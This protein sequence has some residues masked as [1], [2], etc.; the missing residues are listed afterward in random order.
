[1]RI[2]G[3][4]PGKTGGVCIL[5]ER[6]QI[7]DLRRLEPETLP[8]LFK[9]A[10]PHHVAI[11]HAQAFPKDTPLTAFKYGVGFGRLLQ[12]VDVMKLPYTLVKPREWQKIM[13]KGATHWQKSDKSAPKK[14]S[15]EIAR[16]IWPGQ[17]FL[18]TPRCT[19][20]DSGLF[21]AALIAEWC[22]R[23]QIVEGVA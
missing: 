6:G 1:M 2:V 13:H 17:T 11:E 10:P 18:R 12:T 4:D 8:H 14:R 22:R 7:L 21:D 23:T 20:P 3:I 19:K 5:D 9:S 15:L 16:R